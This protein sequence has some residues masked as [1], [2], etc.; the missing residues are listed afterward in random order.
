V[1]HLSAL[2]GRRIVDRRMERVG[3]VADVIVRLGGAGY[4]LVTGLV[5]RVGGRD[6]FLPVSQVGP[7]DED[8]LRLQQ[9]QVD[10]LRFE[11]REGEVLLRADLLK[12]RLIHVPDARLVRAWDVELVASPHEWTV[13]N[14]D[15]RPRRFFGLLPPTGP[16]TPEDWKSFAPLVGHR[17]SARLR[18]VLVSL[19]GLK[20]AQIADLI[21]DASREEQSEILDAV[22]GDPELEADVFEELDPDRQTAV[23]GTRS[24][25]EVADVLSHMRADD[26]ADAIAD[27]PQA[28]RQAVLDLLPPGQRTKV[29]TLLSF[30]PQSAG[31]LMGVDF[32]SAAV[33]TSV[34]DALELV[35]SASTMQ[36]EA[37]ANVY[38]VDDQGRLCG[39]VSLTAL[40]QASPST[41]LSAL[42]EPDPVHV[43]AS[44]DAVDLALRMSDFNLITIPVADEE[45]RV[46]GIVTVDDVLEATIPDDW[47]RREPSPHA[48]AHAV[49]PP[50]TSETASPVG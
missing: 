44:T 4:P 30:N 37:L 19:R 14:V 10:L 31:G 1:V 32:L 20:P 41:P 43:H 8:P 13:Q 47:R 21:E 11:R 27:L 18:R 6:V 33:T 49:E 45:H 26:A 22:H 17:A 9:Q 28:R 23:F 2:L 46:V 40:V 5:G 38:T 24:D 15:T 48:E 3:K 34:A 7:L 12:H 25:P 16:H 42:A 35:R 39:V 36:P 50:S 29:L